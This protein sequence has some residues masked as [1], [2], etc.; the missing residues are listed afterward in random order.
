MAHRAVPTPR[1]TTPPDPTPAVEVP[2]AVA[3]TCSA[4]GH[5][6]TPSVGDFARGRTACPAAGCRGWA[7]TAALVEPAEGG[8]R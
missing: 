2:L 7:F 5:V 6:H 8:V 4:C 1:G 3:L